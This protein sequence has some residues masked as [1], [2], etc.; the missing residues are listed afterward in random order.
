MLIKPTRGILFQ[1][2]VNVID[3]D[4]SLVKQVM[5]HI[6]RIN[7]R[8]ALLLATEYQIDPLVQI[9]T[10]IIAFERLTMHPNKFAS[11]LFCPRRQN[12]VIQCV[13]VLF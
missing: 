3:V 2:I 1:R 9:L 6:N 7:G 8:I 4:I 12:D 13:A 5:K 11:I 10:N